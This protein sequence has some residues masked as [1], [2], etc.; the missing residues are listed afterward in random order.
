MVGELE[1]SELALKRQVRESEEALAAV[2]AELEQVKANQVSAAA[3]KTEL[4]KTKAKQANAIDAATEK[5]HAEGVAKVTES[6]KCQIPK[7]RNA[8]FGVAH[9]A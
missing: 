5:A 7:L 6:Y 4:E 2:R 9:E 1:V 8:I 3:M